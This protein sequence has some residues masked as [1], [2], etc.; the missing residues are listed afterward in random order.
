VSDKSREE[1]WNLAEQLMSSVLDAL[2]KI[3]ALAPDF[4]DELY[5]ARDTHIEGLMVA[6]YMDRFA[7]HALQHKHEIASV[8]AAVGRSRPTDPGDKDPIT[9][10]PYA[11]T[12]YQWFLLEAFLRRAELVSELIGLTDEDLDKKPAPERVAGNDRSIRE[13][14]E[15]VL[16]AQNWKMS[17]IENGVTEY[18]KKQAEK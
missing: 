14:C 3:D 11:R 4:P 9:G 12:W 16:K 2:R 15:H 10:E 1:V 6:D 7:A 18:R 8:R 17:G 13:I 5:E